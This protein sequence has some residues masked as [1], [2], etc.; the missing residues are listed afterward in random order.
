MQP[1]IYIYIEHFLM[2]HSILNLLLAFEYFSKVFI[3][4]LPLFFLPIQNCSKKAMQSISSTFA[5][6]NMEFGN[7]SF[8]LVLLS[9][10]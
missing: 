6:E 4:S 2:M 1:N 9:I 3:F 8:C 5:Y 7:F 10:I